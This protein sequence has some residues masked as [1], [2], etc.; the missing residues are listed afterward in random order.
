MPPSSITEEDFPMLLDNS[1]KAFF[2]RK[3]LTNQPSELR[4]RVLYYS[5]AGGYYHRIKGKCD[6]YVPQWWVEFDSELIWLFTKIQ[7]TW[8]L[9][10]W[11]QKFWE[12]FLFSANKIK[13]L[14]VSSKQPTQL[15]VKFNSSLRH[16]IFTKF[17]RIQA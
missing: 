8:N 4:S 9:K 13:N 11:E 16:I 5:L 14:W 1:H 2:A 10:E 6:N 12:E 3:F 17:C 7:D 15:I